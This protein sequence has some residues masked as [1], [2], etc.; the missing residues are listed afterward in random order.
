MIQVSCSIVLYKTKLSDLNK[1]LESLLR[2]D[3]VSII[4][5][6]DNS[7]HKSDFL[8]KENDRIQY[9]HNSSNLGF[10]SAHNIA[11]DLA[12]KNNFKYHFIVNPDIYFDKGVLNNIINYTLSNDNIGMLMPEILNIDGTIQYLP[13]LFPSIFS[14]FLRRLKISK[15]YI[16]DYELRKNKNQIVDV[17]HL[18]GCFTFLNLNVI[19]EIGGYDEKFFMYFEDWDLSRRVH[20]KY[21]TLYYPKVSVYHGYA[22]EANNKI[23]LFF[24]FIKSMIRYFNKWGWFKSKEIRLKNEEILRKVETLN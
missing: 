23:N 19:K 10:G 15:R 18:S 2:E 21:K 14:V 12:I 17:P 1:V 20:Q 4:Y 16:N 22:S 3:N 5:L 6:I 11:I 9:F 8:F 7:P 24:E 13:K